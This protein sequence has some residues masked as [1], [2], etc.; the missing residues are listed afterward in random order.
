MSKILLVTKN[1]NNNPKGG[2]EKLN[3]LIYMILKDL[4][5][6]NL[7]LFVLKDE[8]I[9]I[10]N[11]KYKNFLYHF[12]AL[13]GYIDGINSTKINEINLLILSNNIN[14]IFIDGSNLGLIAKKIRQKNTFLEIISFFH[15]VEA[16]FFFG[17]FKNKLSFK[18][19]VVMLVNFMV[20]KQSVLYSS[21]LICLNKRDNDLLFSIY[22]KRANYLCSLSMF[23]EHNIIV[24]G[25]KSIEFDY[26][27]F[28]GGFFYANF[29]GI[30]WFIENVKVNKSI[31]I[32]I[33]GKGFEI[34]REQL[35]GNDQVIVVG[36]VDDLSEWYLNSICTIAPI[37]DG[38]GMKTKVAESL[39][40]GKKIIG[41]T[42][43]FIGYDLNI[44]DIGWEC[45]TIFDF[46]NAVVSAFIEKNVNHY[47]KLRQIYLKNYSYDSMKNTFKSILFK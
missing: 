23:D 33:V 5:K 15:N 8:D 30:K 27:L 6:D 38:S 12:N 4:Y 18:S 2:R 13:F 37:F 7:L 29:I 24:N 22:G 14:K 10:K 19:L 3:K 32:V 21:V 31:K 9:N 47:T 34:F 17:E 35:S 43:A 26:L 20:E 45:K 28:V 36:E 11:N 42:E 16:R 1:I 44:N 46:E 25:N 39:M 40:H 41:S